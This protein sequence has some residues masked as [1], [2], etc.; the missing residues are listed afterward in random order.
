M[1]IH[2]YQADS[3]VDLEVFKGLKSRLQN[4]SHVHFNLFR[5]KQNHR[6]SLHDSKPL[7]HSPVFHYLL[8]SLSM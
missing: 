2:D 8:T 6:T 7:L 3:A 4:Q 1:R 5:Q